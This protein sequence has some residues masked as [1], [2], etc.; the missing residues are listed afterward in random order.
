MGYKN[1]SLLLLLVPLLGFLQGTNG[2]PLDPNVVAALEPPKDFFASPFFNS[3][4][5]FILAG[6]GFS[7]LTASGVILAIKRKENKL[8][9]LEDYYDQ[10]EEYFAEGPDYFPDDF[11][12]VFP[13]P[14]DLPTHDFPFPADLP[15]PGG[16]FGYKHLR[17]DPDFGF[18]RRSDGSDVNP[19]SATLPRRRQ[20]SAQGPPASPDIQ[21]AMQEVLEAK[22]TQEVVAKTSELVREVVDTM[23]EDGCLLKL[24]CHLQEK[25]KGDLNVEEKLLL[26]LYNLNARKASP[27]CSHT[28]KCSLKEALLE[29]AFLWGIAAPGA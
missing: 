28:S 19:P 3:W 1:T 5:R 4:A 17:A 12:D 6:F 25:P 21:K 11:P 20:R 23:D 8:A 9:N 26:S 2:Y 18:F 16:W 22:D 7:F 14:N 29:E 13:L 15:G 10:L 27:V 24:L